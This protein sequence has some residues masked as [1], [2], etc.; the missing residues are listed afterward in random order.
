[1]ALHITQML[2]YFL[3]VLF[4]HLFFFWLGFP[5]RIMPSSSAEYSQLPFTGATQTYQST[6]C[7]ILFSTVITI[8]LAKTL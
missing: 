4:L 7:K 3:R 6:K 5:S 2:W 8:L 1:M